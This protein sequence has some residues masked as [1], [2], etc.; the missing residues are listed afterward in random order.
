[1]RGV[2]PH[3]LFCFLN[4]TSPSSDEIR[5]RKISFVVLS[6]FSASAVTKRQFETVMSLKN[7]ANRI[8]LTKVKLLCTN[9]I[10]NMYTVTTS[11]NLHLFN[12]LQCTD[13]VAK[14]RKN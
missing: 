2:K 14:Q 12:H 5:K 11:R 9:Y 3:L 1:M 7:P 13:I 10:K 4:H 6:F 8:H